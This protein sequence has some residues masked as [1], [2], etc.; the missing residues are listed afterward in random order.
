MDEEGSFVAA[1]GAPGSANG[2]KNDLAAELFV[3]VGDGLSVE[4]G[5]LK[6]KRLAGI[7]DAGETRR[8]R[9]FGNAF[10]ARFRSAS[11]QVF[12]EPVVGDIERAVRLERG[13]KKDGTLSGEV[14]EDKSVAA[15]AAGEG[16]GVS[17][18]AQNGAGNI[19]TGLAEIEFPGKG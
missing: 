8:I 10:G 4:I 16:A 18:N 9:R 13:F 11:G 6:L 14:A 15:P 7:S 1:V 5:K 12:V 3:G 17:V 19:L 2:H